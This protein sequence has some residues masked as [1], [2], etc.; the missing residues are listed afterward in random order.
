MAQLLST[1]ITG[2]LATSGILTGGITGNVVLQSISYFGTQIN[3]NSNS[4]FQIST[5]NQSNGT[6]AS[7]DVVA[8]NDIG[9]DTSFYVDLGI[10]SSKYNDPAYT[11]MKA[12]DA[13]LY[14]AGGNLAIGTANVDD[15]IVF[16]ANGTLSS[17]ESMRIYGANNNI[18][19][20][21][22]VIIA[23]NVTTSRNISAGNLVATYNVVTYNITSASGTSAN[24]VIDPDGSGNLVISTATP[25]VF[26]NNVTLSSNATGIMIGAN[27]FLL[28][29]TSDI[30]PNFA[31]ANQAAFYTKNVANAVM[32]GIET[33]R[34][35]NGTWDPHAYFQ[36]SMIN[37]IVGYARPNLFAT[38]NT[39]CFTGLGLT[40]NCIAL[41]Q[42][43]NT[44]NGIPTNTAPVFKNTHRRVQ[45]GA[46]ANATTGNATVFANANTLWMGGIT[47]AAAGNG[48]GFIY[49]VKFAYDTIASNLRSFVGLTNATAAFVNQSADYE[50]RTN[51]VYSMFGVG[52][53]VTSAGNMWLIYGAAGAARTATDLGSSFVFNTA[54]VYEL[55]IHVP[56]GGGSVGYRV[57]NLNNGAEVQGV[58]TTNIPAAN[59]FLQPIV[60]LKSNTAAVS[61]ISIMNM[62]YETDQ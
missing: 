12:N 47:G 54:D 1:T 24:I 7:S 42:Y 27:G 46:N 56:P 36:T 13:Y 62:Y 53:N 5:Q 31:S 17:N 8:H 37:K 39:T 43:C 23:G 4:F 40:V 57:R 11:I 48:G 35:N 59:T 45:I 29:N 22:N 34:A 14:V 52:A 2:N 19:V 10:N 16:F 51:T 38:T 26:G 55:I 30:A 6:N 21:T 20:S 9:T 61:N 18:N 60:L 3:G 44:S 33:Q 58:T 15:D 49:A 25:T 28:I 41:T 50:P 32:F